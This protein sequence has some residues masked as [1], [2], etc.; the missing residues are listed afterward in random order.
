MILLLS[1]IF[2]SV[3]S[4]HG[5]NNR[6]TGVIFTL[7]HSPLDVLLNLKTNDW[8]VRKGYILFLSM[9]KVLNQRLVS[10]T[11]DC[12]YLVMLTFFVTTYNKTVAG[13]L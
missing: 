11:A 12:G 9:N 10:F 8:K 13:W 5:L 2:V 1:E 3:V 4:S 7:K 6:R